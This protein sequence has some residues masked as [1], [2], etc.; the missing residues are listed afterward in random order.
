MGNGSTQPSKTA[1]PQEEADKGSTPLARNHGATPK[2]LETLL[3][4]PEEAK[5][6]HN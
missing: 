4:P 5:A 3:V 6:Q 1:S 2:T